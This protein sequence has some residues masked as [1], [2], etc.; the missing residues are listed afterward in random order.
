MGLVMDFRASS[1]LTTSG[2][3]TSWR[4]SILIVSLQQAAMNLM[5]FQL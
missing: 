5:W 2:R 3:V 1:I 4:R